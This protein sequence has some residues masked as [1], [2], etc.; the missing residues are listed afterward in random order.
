MRLRDARFTSHTLSLYIVPS[1]GRALRPV[2]RVVTVTVVGTP[3][4]WPHPASALALRVPVAGSS[5]KNVGMRAGARERAAQRGRPRRAS[6]SG[7]ACGPRLL[8]GAR[9]GA[10]LL[11][12]REAA[13][14]LAIMALVAGVVAAAHAGNAAG[15]AAV[16][17]A[18]LDGQ[19]AAAAERVAMFV[20]PLPSFMRTLAR[21]LV[22][23]NVTERVSPAAWADLAGAFVAALPYVSAFALMDVVAGPDRAAWEAATSAEYA[24]PIVMLDFTAS[25]AP[26]CRRRI[27]YVVVADVIGDGSSVSIPGRNSLPDQPRAAAILDAL[28]TGDVSITNGAKRLANSRAAFVLFVPVYWSAAANRTSLLSLTLE[29]DIVFDTAVGGVAGASYYISIGD[30]QADGSV[31]ALY[32]DGVFGALA[33]VAPHVTN[34]KFV[35][36]TLRVMLGP[37]VGSINAVVAARLTSTLSWGAPIVAGI[38]LVSVVLMALRLLASVDATRG[39]LAASEATRD[40]IMAFFFHEL[41]NPLQAAMGLVQAMREDSGGTSGPEHR[42]A[43]APLPHA[44]VAF[45]VS[46]VS[47]GRSGHTETSGS[48]DS[49]D[50]LGEVARQLVRISGVM[51]SLL[52]VT[53]IS[54]GEQAAVAVDVDVPALLRD[55]A[56]VR[57]RS[58]VLCC[59]SPPFFEILYTDTKY[60]CGDG[61]R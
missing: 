54:H 34:V 45:P 30:V 26:S 37:S 23:G 33:G 19:G 16:V 32:E 12:W 48:P 58:N 57:R 39:A 31:V 9:E 25:N 11:G 35:H 42:T 59:A 20:E 14:C 49:I 43:T 47:S 8:R 50:G 17:Q 5:S 44:A 10:A 53:T 36:R 21:A 2:L 18:T 51:D 4:P 28:A 52:E 60:T 3:T 41:R 15:D 24:R 55:V 27:C 56:Q 13:G 29:D 46:G 22:L 1:P 6:A 61:S 38:G 40:S 7:C